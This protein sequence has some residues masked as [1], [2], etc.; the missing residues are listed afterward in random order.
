MFLVASL[1]ALFGLSSVAMPISIAAV[2]ALML[3]VFL[4]WLKCGRDVLPAKAALSIVPS[5][6]GKLGIYGR[7]LSRRLDARWIKTDRTKSERNPGEY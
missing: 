2:S 7:I 6:V 3:A 5:V 1:T 4:A